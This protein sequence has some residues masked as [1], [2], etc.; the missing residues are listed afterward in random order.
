TVATGGANPGADSFSAQAVATDTGSGG[1][2]PDVV[3]TQNGI[4]LNGSVN[5]G[6]S[7][8]TMAANQDGSGT[9][10]LTQASGTS[11]QTTNATASAI[12]VKV[13]TTTGTGNAAL[14]LLQTGSGG[15]ASVLVN[16]G[17]ITDNN[18]AANNVNATNLILKATG[19]TGSGRGTTT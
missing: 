6:A 14:G 7:T 18:G 4:T 3:R 9:E 2:F 15:T 5:A 12:S 19:G 13:N 16:G 8:V 17:A 10:G 11:V 1:T